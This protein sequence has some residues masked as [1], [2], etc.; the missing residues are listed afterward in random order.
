MKS[1]LV[2][3]VCAFSMTVGAAQAQSG[4]WSFRADQDTGIASWAGDASQSV[5]FRCARA[6]S[7]VG[8]ADSVQW[9]LRVPSLV[10]ALGVS[11]GRV[12]EVALDLDGAK[13]GS[14]PFVRQGQ[15]AATQIGRAATILE[16]MRSA[17]ELRLGPVGGATVASVPLDGFG[18]ALDELVSFCGTPAGQAEDS[19]DE[20]VQAQSGGWSFKA[21]QTTGVARWEGE[22]A[23]S[24]EFRC[25][26]PRPGAPNAETVQWW[27]RLPSLVTS[28]GIGE[29]EVGK[30]TL[31][32]DGE[33]RGSGPFV[34]QGDAAATQIGRTSSILERMRSAKELRLGTESGEASVTVSLSD[35]DAAFDDLVGFCEEAAPQSESPQAQAP[36]A[37]APQAQPG[38]PPLQIPAVQPL[39]PSQLASVVYDP[40]QIGQVVLIEL[41]RQQPALLDSDAILQSWYMSA[42]SDGKRPNSQAEL[43]QARDHLSRSVAAQPAGSFLIGFEA[44]N[45]FM[46]GTYEQGV[47]S[48]YGRNGA[49]GAATSHG[50]G[51]SQ[52]RVG[53]LTLDLRAS[54]RFDIG[55]VA[56]DQAQAERMKDRNV[57]LL[58][59][60]ELTG[61]E[62]FGT[63][64]TGFSLIGEGTV[65]FVGLKKTDPPQPRQNG[66]PAPIKR[67]D[68]ALLVAQFS[69]TPPAPPAGGLTGMA[70][71]LDLPMYQGAVLEGAGNAGGYGNQGVQ[72]LVRLMALRAHPPEEIS[73]SLR[74]FTYNVLADPAERDLIIP[75]ASIE[76]YRNE[77][78]L[79]FARHVD[80][81]DR[82]EL[83]D[84]IDMQLWPRVLARLP[85]AP[86][87]GIAM[88]TTN[89]GEYDRE[90]GGFPLYV[91]ASS[92]GL[93]A[94]GE[95]P[96]LTALPDL[97]PLRVEQAR[98]LVNY[99]DTNFGPGRRQVTIVLRYRLTDVGPVDWDTRQMPATS[100]EPLSLSLHAY[101]Q[102]KPGDDPLAAKI[103][104][105]DLAAYRGASRPVASPERV[106]FWKEIRSA[107]RSTYDDVALAALGVSEDNAY[108][109]LLVENS[110]RVQSANAF[111]RD[112]VQQ[113]VRAQLASADTPSE[114][115]LGG[116]IGLGDY[117]LETERYQS[118][119]VRLQPERGEMGLQPPQ[120]RFTDT[121][122]LSTLDVPEDIARV[123]ARDSGGAEASAALI[124]WVKPDLLVF[125]NDRPVLY[126]TPTRIVVMPAFEDA[127]G[128]P[129]AH[130]EVALPE[131]GSSSPKEAALAQ[132]AVDSPSSLPLDSEYVDLLMVKERGDALDEATYLRMLEDRRLRELTAASLGTTPP[133]GTF[134]DNPQSELNPM[135]RRSLLPAFIEWTRKRT[136][137]LPETV[138]VQTISYG[139]TPTDFRCWTLTQAPQSDN[140]NYLPEGLSRGLDAMEYDKHIVNLQTFA[141]AVGSEPHRQPETVYAIYGRPSLIGA[142]GV[143]IDGTT[144]ACAGSGYRPSRDES[145]A[146]GHWNALVRVEGAYRAP[147]PRDGVTVFRD[148]GT[149]EVEEIGP[150]TVQITLAADRTELLDLAQQGGRVEPVRRALLD[151]SALPAPPDALDLFGIGPGDDWESALEQAQA[152]LPEAVVVKA[153]GPPPNFRVVSQNTILG[154]L[155]EFNALR[156][157]HF[158]FDTDKNEVLFLA[159]EAERDPKR[160][161]AVGSYRRFD[162]GQVTQQQLIGALLRKYGAAPQTESDPLLRGPRPGQTLTWGARAGCLPQMRDELRPDW[163]Q[164]RDRP[165]IQALQNVARNFRAPSL[166]YNAAQSI[167]YEECTPAVWALVG[168]DSEGT[169][170]LV[171]WSIDMALL[172]EVAQK[173]DPQTVADG[174]SGSKTLIEDAADIDL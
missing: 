6:G 43:A 156:N 32:F 45:P 95:Y 22:G 35:F 168:E 123:L 131:P 54:S 112:S 147:V 93:A 57:R 74:A 91:N 62:S 99:F 52:L 58:V 36:Q 24:V 157:G 136:E 49:D 61:V 144:R 56:V 18:A 126:V 141:R 142:P 55:E 109:N 117:A 37:E 150:E 78:R 165:D 31:E 113:T 11:E 132:L 72:T 114:L 100:I 169:L 152:R 138:Y 70:E 59:V 167:I 139:N 64:E 21:G 9:W 51:R 19:A 135:Q 166:T 163:D 25:S 107:T 34:R 160:V 124:A 104:D 174:D 86:F 171:V 29:G 146:M 164:L 81:F 119:S 8:A 88:Q 53:M 66:Q 5:E 28:L 102:F 154:P 170:H 42:L 73:E 15:A 97:L 89:L 60:T 3:V 83:E 75:P 110:N 162:A 172:D 173:P 2:S 148:L 145:P 125:E 94:L 63:P 50:L 137:L 105:F 39:D 85:Q 47:L 69:P 77:Q 48:A 108:L 76:D 140:G 12:A 120:I 14:G 155:P 30:V 41:V 17:S 79:S 20:P 46:N 121:S 7:A 84:R 4:G 10:S 128:Y 80:E 143:R 65:R 106:A 103:M 1:F 129:P 67:I 130:V 127:T 159:R 101:G 33:P 26:R 116:Q 98:E 134:F 118:T 40:R 27:L 151:E 87:E 68:P 158:F 44:N 161:L 82:A 115:V 111:D 153:D 133:W 13:S 122:L 38:L 92:M 90:R 149:V 16:R 96:A 23:S 71:T